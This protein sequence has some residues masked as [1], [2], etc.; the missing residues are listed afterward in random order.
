MPQCANRKKRL[1]SCS[2]LLLSALCGARNDLILLKQQIETKV[3]FSG[4]GVWV[5]VVLEPLKL[6]KRSIL[7]NERVEA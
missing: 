6:D 1:H 4:A 5:K 2:A 7:I 3:V